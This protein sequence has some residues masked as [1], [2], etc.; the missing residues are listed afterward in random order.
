M[1]FQANL[2]YRARPCLPISKKKQTEDTG[3]VPEWPTRLHL[4]MYL[5]ISQTKTLLK[6]EGQRKN[7][8]VQTQK[9]SHLQRRATNVLN[10][11]LG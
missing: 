6:D 8:K 10:S 9:P 7:I 5:V 3:K 1:E 11:S 4:G 2:S